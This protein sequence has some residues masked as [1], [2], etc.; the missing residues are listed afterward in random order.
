MDITS[1]LQE[2]FDANAI[3]V[4]NTFGSLQWDAPPVRLSPNYLDLPANPI[5]DTENFAQLPKHA[6]LVKVAKFIH[7]PCA[8]LFDAL[9]NALPLA[10]G[11]EEA[12]LKQITEL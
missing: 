4:V 7:S 11:G 1:R 8:I 12:H 6:K 3:Q 10:E 9:V 2:K 5:E